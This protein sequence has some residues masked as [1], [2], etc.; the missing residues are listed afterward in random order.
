MIEIVL[1]VKERLGM[2]SVTPCPT[3]ASHAQHQGRVIK[4]WTNVTEYSSKYNS[5]TFT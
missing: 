3:H 1:N 2:L 5:D 4:Q